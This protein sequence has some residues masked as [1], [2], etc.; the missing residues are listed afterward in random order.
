M[1]FFVFT[2]LIPLVFF[3]LLIAIIS[4]TFDRVYA[5]KVASDYREKASLILEVESILL[6]RR[7]GKKMQLLKYIIRNDTGAKQGS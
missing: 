1:Y 7:R 3:N 2:L 4:D 5:N 6:W